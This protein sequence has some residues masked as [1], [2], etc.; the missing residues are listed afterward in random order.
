MSAFAFAET[1]VFGKQSLEPISCHPLTLLLPGQL[2]GSPFF[3][4]YGVILPSSLT[5]GRSFTWGDFSLPTSVGLRY[6]Q[7]SI[8]LA[9]FLGG[10]G[11]K[12]FRTLARAR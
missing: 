2:L 5:E 7:S 10:L 6:G 9:A 1:C 3:R 12:D 4:R 8:W 11:F